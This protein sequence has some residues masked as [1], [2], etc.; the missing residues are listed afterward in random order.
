MTTALI[1]HDAFDGH[2]TPDGMPERVAR[3][4]AVRAALED[5]DLLRVEAPLATDDDVTTLHTEGHVAR[6]RASVPQSGFAALDSET[7]LAPGSEEA[8]FRA[9]GGALKA[10]D[11]VMA[12]EVKNAFVAARPPGHHAEQATPMG[13]CIFGNVALAARHAMD[14][15]GL[16]RVA[17]VDFDVHHGNGTQALL[18]DEPR[19]LVVTSH[20]M[21]LWPGT[22]YPD[23]RGPHDTIVN[24]PL[25]PGTDGGAMRAAY[26][27]Q[28]FPRLRA[29]RPELILISAGFDAH[30]ADPLAQ[31]R[32][33]E[34]DFAWVTRELCALAAELCDSRVVSCL[35]GGYDLD[36]LGASARAH[37][38][39]LM[40]AP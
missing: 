16:D 9:V 25:A 36:A 27:Q 34:G 38:L 40:E 30:A 26:T 1:T 32:W 10:V 33:V 6:I 35:E 37:V 13:F 28:V 31:L 5:L 39:E 21:P 20:Q 14:A 18:W 15:H 3:L 17:V 23:E 12:K 4:E 29:F 11:M 7:F 19:A 8:A 24:V 22:G 2:V